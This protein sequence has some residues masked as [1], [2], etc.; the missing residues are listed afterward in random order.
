MGKAVEDCCPLI[1]MRAVFPPAGGP[2]WAEHALASRAAITTVR[3]PADRIRRWTWRI[4]MGLPLAGP[5]SR[6]S[7]KFLECSKNRLS[8][9]GAMNSPRSGFRRAAVASWALAGLGAAGVA[10]ASALAYGDTARPAEPVADVADQALP[11]QG[12]DPAPAVPQPPPA[13]MPPA[14][15]SPPPAPSPPPDTSTETTVVQTPVRTY[16]PAPTYSRQTTP[17]QAP[18]AT[19][20]AAPTTV[21]PRTTQ[22]RTLT[23]ATVVSPNFSPHV[24]RSRGS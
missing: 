20:T 19:Q 16:T 12:A 14:P 2:D 13:A 9:S 17:A 7:P 15:S 21:A 22:R 8:A 6:D 1:V 18:V 4:R 24:S 23:P 11:S 10:G 3:A 5:F